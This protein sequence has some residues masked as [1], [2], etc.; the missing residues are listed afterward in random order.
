V[1]ALDGR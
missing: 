1:N